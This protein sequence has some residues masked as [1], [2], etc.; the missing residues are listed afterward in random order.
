MVAV[1]DKDTLMIEI[2]VDNQEVSELL[3]M[4]KSMRERGWVQGRDFDFTYHPAEY[5]YT[6]DQTAEQRTVFTFYREEIAIVFALTY[7]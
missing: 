1:A 7:L 2:V 3:P 4:V 6:W 5:R